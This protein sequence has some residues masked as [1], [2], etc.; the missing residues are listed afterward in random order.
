MAAVNNLNMVCANALV[1]N[2]E[3]N[4]TLV[5]FRSSWTTLYNVRFLFPPWVIRITTTLSL[6]AEGRKEGGGSRA[7]V[8]S[9]CARNKAR[10]FSP[11]E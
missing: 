6:H 2:P 7:E 5:P 1:V 9:D 8:G 3:A 11:P 4:S 10:G